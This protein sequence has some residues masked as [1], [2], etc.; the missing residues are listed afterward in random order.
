[1]G[2]RTRILDFELANPIYRG[3]S[4]T[5][6]TVDVAGVKTATKATLYATPTGVTTLA[7][8]QRLDSKGKFAQAVYADVPVI[9][10]VDGIH[11][12]DHDTG[13]IFPLGLFR[14]DWA[15]GTLYYPSEFVRD[16]AAGANTLDIYAVQSIHTAGVWA[17]DSADATKLLRLINV[18]GATLGVSLPLPVS[19]GGT[20]ATTPAGAQAGLGLTPHLRRLTRGFIDRHVFLSTFAR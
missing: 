12:P 6:F 10:S 14:G 19:Q 5:F 11:V 20:G 1:M 3:A 8:P 18:G 7:N 17:T 15:A 13:I 16:G 9:G 4:V 2:A